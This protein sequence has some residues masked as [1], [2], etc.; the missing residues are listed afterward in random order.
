MK[1]DCLSAASVRYRPADCLILTLNAN[2]CPPFCGPV[3]VD[4]TAVPPGGVVTA[5]AINPRTVS[6]PLRFSF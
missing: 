2:I 5:R 3:E 6:A 1:L 4:G